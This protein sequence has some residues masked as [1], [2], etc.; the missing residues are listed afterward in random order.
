MINAFTSFDMT[1]YHITMASR[2]AA[3]GIDV[4]ADSVRFSTFDPDELA[5]EMEVV[6]EEIRRGDDSP[7]RALSQGLFSLSY[8][9]HPYKLPVIG[10]QESV[11]SFSREQM[12]E[13][14]KRWYVPNNMTF[15]IV[16]DVDADETLAQ[17]KK[18]F[19]G[20]APSKNLAHPR[21]AESTQDRA[22]ARLLRKPFDQTLVGLAYP[23]PQFANEDTAHVD[24]MSWV[25]GGGE[26]SRLY[27]QV[28]DRKQLVH[29]V[30]A[31]AYTPLDPGLFFIDVSL[32]PENIEAAIASIQD[33]IRR[34]A[35]FGPSAQELE[36]ARINLL[37]HEVHEKET[38]QGQA[39]KYG[40]FETLANGIEEEAE[41]LERIRNATV[42][43]LQHAAAK[44]LRPEL[45]SLVVL[46]P[47]AERP[48]LD[49]ARLLALLEAKED[50]APTFARKELEGGILHY[51][52]DNGLRVVVKPNK[53]VGLV[54]MRL[55][56]LGGLL[57]ETADTQGIT[58]FTSEMIE[59]GTE[60]RSAAQFAAEVESLAGG[61]SGF[62]GR[63]TLGITAEFLSKNLDSGLELFSDVLLN[64]SFDPAEIDKLREET[65]AAL[66][67]REDNLQAKAFEI[68]SEGLYPNHPYRF[69]TLGN[70]K[71]VQS[72]DRDSL[73]QL[74]GRWAQPSNGVLA[75]V[76]DVDPDAVVK[77]I[78]SRLAEWKDSE[79]VSLP[80]RTAL[81]PAKKARE[82][83]LEKGRSQVHLIVG[84]TGLT[85]EDPD[86]PA[87][88]V[89]TQVLAG[90]GGRLFLE[91]RDRQ[92]LAYV[93]TAF[94][95]E[96]IDPGSFGVY[97]ASDPAKL[98][99]ARK[100]LDLE[101][102]KILDEPVTQ[103]EIDRSKA[104][105]IGSQAVSLQRFGS[106]A[107][108]LSLEELYGLGA[109]H[110]LE[111]ESR[112]EAVTADDLSRVAKR[113][114]KLDAPLTAI[115]K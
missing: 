15:V 81:E 47:E 73:Q 100:G 43:D 72:F 45:A 75:I 13:F 66:R 92:S 41:Y 88:E 91:L 83:S 103:A 90:Q 29:A 48:D 16:G 30:S 109:A 87:L 36:R 22:R 68:F 84:F 53:A 54:S 60:Q 105:L 101:L 111:Y 9:D 42:E 57:A 74:W 112:I 8:K 85:M 115:V 32:E 40:Y 27:R 96:G 5:S 18:S 3:T 58:A 67:R 99:Q 89:L 46:V 51:T 104:Y 80:D 56:F 1:V 78:A 69:P 113:I 77:A 37:S 2:D 6:V 70:E 98:D 61:I 10:T 52:L 26:S 55:S 44:Y 31:S 107:S 106:Q 39:R 34:L 38:M 108:L 17:V 65:L 28:K 49:D 14:H 114:I 59:K 50:R 33:E 4:L 25:L 23:A 35:E 110:H 12:L 21:R 86:A 24:L 11:R 102:R 93:V 7:G 94:S 79:T 64:P 62:S 97:I 71:T 76:G 19:A 82:V 63:N 20:A 95:N